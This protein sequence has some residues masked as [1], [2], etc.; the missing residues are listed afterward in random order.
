MRK[1]TAQRQADLRARRHAAGMV[2]AQIWI[3]AHLK[4]IIENYAAQLM[5]QS[6]GAAAEI[7]D[8]GLPKASPHE[9]TTP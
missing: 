4:P 8:A 6:P 2:C 5:Q 3:P 9:E 1:T 7:S